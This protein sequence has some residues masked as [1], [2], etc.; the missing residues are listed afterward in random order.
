MQRHIGILKNDLPDGG[1]G[2]GVLFN[3]LGIAQIQLLQRLAPHKGIDAEVT[4]LGVY[5]F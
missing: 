2:Q 3:A 4:D 5:G 1:S